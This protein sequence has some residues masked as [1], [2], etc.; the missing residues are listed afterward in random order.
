MRVYYLCDSHHA[1]LT[2]ALRRMKVSRVADLNDPFELLPINLRD[3][4]LR[5]LLHSTREQFHQ[6]Y[7][8]LCFSRAWSNPVLWSHYADKHRGICLGFDVADELIKPI[9][10]VPRLAQVSINSKFTK[11]SLVR[12][13]KE[14]FLFTKFVGWQY[15]DEVRAF[16][17]S[18]RFQ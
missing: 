5:T 7:G 17:T 14:Q 8:V 9:S 12:F 2:I 6:E 1:L 4:R 10:Y 11:E 15:E 13:I 18:P 16:A 3:K